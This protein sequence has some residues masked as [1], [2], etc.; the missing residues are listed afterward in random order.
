M[1]AR[2]PGMNP[3]NWRP[4]DIFEQPCPSCGKP[5]EFWKDDVMRKCPGCSALIVNNRIDSTCMAW[6]DKAAECTGSDDISIWK[7]G[8]KPKIK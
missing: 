2:C 4:Q 5:V 3:Q 8:K 6:C 7:S 1:N